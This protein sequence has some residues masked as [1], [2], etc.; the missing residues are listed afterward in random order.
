ML[1][2]FPL[3]PEMLQTFE[4]V[5]DSYLILSPDLIILTASEAYLE[6]T[7]SQRQEIAGKHLFEAFPGNP[8]TL[9]SN[10]VHKLKDSLQ[11]VLHSRKPHQMAMQRYDVPRPQ[12]KGG[13]FE[14]K[15][16]KVVNSPV[17]DDQGAVLYIIH[18]VNDVTE[19]VKSQQQ[20]Q[21]LTIR[22]QAALSEADWE[23]K[24]LEAIFMQAPVAIGIYGGKEHIVELINPCMSELLKRPAVDLLGKSILEV[25]P[26][27]EGKRFKTILAE[28]FS[29]GK[30]F[31]AREVAVSLERE[32]GL[33]NG[34]YNTAYQPLR[35]SKGEITGII[36]IVS[37]VSSQVISRQKIEKRERQIRLITDSLPVLI[38]YLDKEEKYRFANKAYEKW[39]P[40]KPNELLG[41]P[42][43]EVVGE[44]AYKG[45]KGYIQR[46]LAGER[47]DFEAKMPYREGFIKHIRTSYVP[48]IQKGKVEGFYTLVT[49]ITEQVEIRQSIQEREKEAQD[50]ARELEAANEELRAANQQIRSTNE[51]LAGSNRQL[52]H[53]NADMDNFIYTA[54]HDLRAPIVNIEGLMNSLLG[55]LPK[56]IQE[57][58]LN[59]KLFSMVHDS[60]ERFKKTLDELT[61]ISKIQRDGGEEELDPVDLSQLIRE[62]QL[63]LAQQIQQT[64]ARFEL[65]LENGDSIS[66]SAKNARSI[67]Y[68]LISNAIKYHSPRRQPLIRL[69]TR[70]EG[71]YLVFSVEDNGL[72]MKYTDESKIFGMFKR[73][74]DHVDGTGV[75]LHMVKKIIENAGGR[76]EV[77]SKLDQGSTFRVYFRK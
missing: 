24:K 76:I 34:Y 69:S 57:E 52:S 18:K 70:R 49:D 32:G 17:L 38:G 62:V 47:L 9:Q 21:D 74:H 46:A 26:E 48:D 51:E 39:F 45:V 37:E 28:V 19:Q 42:V 7:L 63:D 67:V 44:K 3:A 73:L 20:I 77:Q 15:Y 12:Q 16:W 14:E 59:H 64:D 54:S 72:G 27:L 36:N 41:R 35:N 43:R 10:S 5:P 75:G 58:P 11:K 56:D 13:G 66:L 6:A 53:I 65:D 22:E 61:E 25:L 68:N 40:L 8:Q 2:K 30:S 71:E 55:K 29:S 50:L 31:E 1:Q 33:E 4:S 60:I 23:R